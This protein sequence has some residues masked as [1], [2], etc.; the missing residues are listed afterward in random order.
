MKMLLAYLKR[1]YLKTNE[2]YVGIFFR[3]SMSEST[4]R[5]QTVPSLVS[6]PRSTP[7]DEASVS[8]LSGL[9]GGVEGKRKRPPLWPVPLALAVAMGVALAW[10]Q[11]VPGVLFDGGL[12]PEP[13]DAPIVENAVSSSAP[14]EA[15]AQNQNPVGASVSDVAVEPMGAQMPPSV[16]VIEEV[17]PPA[18]LPSGDSG[19]DPGGASAAVEIGLV[20]PEA[21]E[22]KQL[23][24]TRPRA[25]SRKAA[26]AARKTTPR[27]E[28][29]S[30]DADVDII[31]AIVKGVSSR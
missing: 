14:G 5:S 23:A 18:V 11:G 9:S 26:P 2:F 30:G 31:T 29:A 25:Q 16:A 6:T 7:A 13:G 4:I 21:A 20:S 12:L 8:I 3:K 28:S 1:M 27:A 19:A 24:T 17:A 22:P 10:W 15:P